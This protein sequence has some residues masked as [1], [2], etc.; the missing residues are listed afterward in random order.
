MEIQNINFLLIGNQFYLYY[1][2]YIYIYI[3]NVYFVHNFKLVLII[4]NKILH[5]KFRIKLVVEYEKNQKNYWDVWLPKLLHP[6]T[7]TTTWV[8]L[9]LARHQGWRKKVILPFNCWPVYRKL[10]YGTCTWSENIPHVSVSGIVRRKR[11]GPIA[12]SSYLPVE[13]W[14]Y[15]MC[16]RLCVCVCVCVWALYW[17]GAAHTKNKCLA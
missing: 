1:Y 15:N 13:N 7:T 8:S 16:V 3:Q 12:K 2:I 4:K 5:F 11:W 10:T 17:I 9:L 14:K 6:P